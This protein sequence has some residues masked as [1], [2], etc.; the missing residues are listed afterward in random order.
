[1]QPRLRDTPLLGPL[2]DHQ[3][4][5]HCTLKSNECG[6][7]DAMSVLMRWFIYILQS[8][9]LLLLSTISSYSLSMCDNHESSGK[10][11]EVTIQHRLGYHSR[12]L[13]LWQRSRN[14]DSLLQACY[15]HTSMLYLSPRQLCRTNP[16]HHD[17]G[18]LINSHRDRCHSCCATTS[19]ESTR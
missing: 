10:V 2:E 5:T 12:R 15:P 3:C 4:N 14:E 19:F 9:V 1:M 6:A 7:L 17:S 18:L 11:A 16:R 8:R 13:L